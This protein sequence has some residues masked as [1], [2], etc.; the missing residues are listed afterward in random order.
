M[1]FIANS[2]AQ[3]PQQTDCLIVGVFTQNELS[4]TAQELDK[5]SQGAISAFLAQ[6][7]LKGKVG[8]AALLYKLDGVNAN[9]V[10]LVGCGDKKGINDQEF[11][12]LLH[13]AGNYLKQTNAASAVYALSDLKVGEHDSIWQ[14]RQAVVTLRDE[15]Y[16]FTQL[17]G[18]SE[19]TAEAKPDALKQIDFLAPKDQTAAQKAIEAGTI[20]ASSVSVAKDLAYLPANICTP[21]YLAEQALQAAKELPALKVEILEEAQMRELK[22]GALLAVSQGSQQAP[23][24]VMIHY[25]GAD[26]NT[27]PI[28]LVGKGITFD[29]GGISLKPSANIVGMKF[30]MCGAATVLA[31]LRAA[32]A[33]KL[34]LNIIGIMVCVENMIGSH[35]YRPDDVITSMSGQTIEVNNTDAEGRLILCDALTY[36]AR[37]NPD[38]VI[39]MATLTGAIVVALG[40]H[41]SGVF[42]NDQTLANDLLQA[43]QES[44]DRAWQLPIWEEYQ[45]QLDS[46]VADMVNSAT[47]GG[48]SITAA[49]F[50]SRFTKNYKWAHLDIAGTAF[51]TGSKAVATGRPVALLVQYLLDR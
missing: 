46:G 32:A 18:K 43:G 6:G 3:L 39:D 8:Q 22:M 23:K 2:I 19:L 30:D 10:L 5:A 50:L 28:V 27:K 13:T 33:L 20:I 31:T 29:T 21:S 1:E 11:Y 17:K 24:F 7:D 4:S 34:P 40:K 36:C 49:C 45:S 51:Q 15:L 41:A 42:S 44:G 37:F 35:A 16:S 25:Q 48:N 9:R 14:L 47:S 26:A 12:K 38:V